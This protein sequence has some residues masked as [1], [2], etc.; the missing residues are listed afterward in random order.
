MGQEEIRFSFERELNLSFSGGSVRPLRTETLSGTHIY[1]NIYISLIDLP[2]KQQFPQVQITIG[3]SRCIRRRIK[4]RSRVC[5][6]D[7]SKCIGE[8]ASDLLCE[9][10]GMGC[11]L[12]SRHL[13][14][15]LWHH[16]YNKHVN[17]MAIAAVIS[18]VN[19]V[20]NL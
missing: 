13:I 4:T 5:K 7:L 18:C 12:Q 9:L 1:M 6:C 3:S 20:L 11:Q 14:A 15:H 10:R 16:R 2:F 17:I 8:F 19:V